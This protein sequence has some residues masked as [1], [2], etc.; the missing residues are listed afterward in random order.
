MASSPIQINDRPHSASS[1]SSRG[2]VKKLPPIHAQDDIDL[3]TD[4]RQTSEHLE[5]VSRTKKN[6]KFPDNEP[7]PSIGAGGDSLENDKEKEEDGSVS[8]KEQLQGRAD[9][10]NEDDVDSQTEPDSSPELVEEDSDDESSDSEGSSSVLD[11]PGEG[12]THPRVARGYRSEMSSTDFPPEGK[13]DHAVAFS[14]GSDGRGSVSPG[15]KNLTRRRTYD[16]REVVFATIDTQTD[17]NWMSSV[18]DSRRVKHIIPRGKADL[19]DGRTDRSMDTP[20]DDKTTDSTPFPGQYSDE[21]GIPILE[22]SSDTDESSDEGSS[23]K[24]ERNLMPNVGPPQ[25]LQ[26]IR[27]SEREETFVK[28][29]D[30]DE[31]DLDLRGDSGS[32]KLI[33][34]F[35]GT[36]EF[37]G[38]AVKPMPSLEQQAKESP[39]KLY[40]C[41]GYAEFVEFS[42]TA[43]HMIEEEVKRK[44]K[45]I[46]VKVHAH[47]GSK[48][49]RRAAKERA[50]QRIREREMQRKQQ[51]VQGLQQANF[52]ALARQMKTINYSLSS[53]RCL[54]EGWT[55][56]PPSPLQEEEIQD[57]F[58]AEPVLM[59]TTLQNKGLPC[60]ERF[61]DDGT[62]FL[63]IFADGTGNVFY[64]SGNV[65]IMITA[66]E[67]PNQFIYLICEDKPEERVMAVFEP[68]GT[69]CC[70]H[71]NGVIRVFIDKLGGIEL[72]A[73]G[74]KKRR[75]KWIDMEN[76]V[77]APPLQ[78]I[79][80]TLTKY[81]GIRIMNQDNIAVTFSCKKSSCRFNVGVKLKLVSLENLENL[82]QELDDDQ[83][84]LEEQRNNVQAVLDKI[85]NLLKFPKSPKIDKILPPI[86][87][88]SKIH[89]TEKLKK[90]RAKQIAARAAESPKSKKCLP[91]ITVN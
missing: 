32:E 50:V 51:D 42:I 59:M 91:V 22:L 2:S 4:K 7:L 86:H 72:E 90:T 68:N 11:R 15:F 5:E 70:Y 27:E 28:S 21:Y 14:P 87:L 85:S 53:N 34:M 35:C 39:E 6:V 63:T 8:A 61:Y 66:A 13:T 46:D 81:I 67:K 80:F 40:C 89:K 65:A 3:Q 48:Q 69:G 26:Y 64:P 76:H 19:Q 17:W 52:Y 29:P 47:H 9:N 74:A 45:L 58:E 82:Q 16:G 49:A 71:S 83:I 41:N 10:K 12:R 31:E 79:C 38:N 78:P 55:I 30:G 43:S 62:K 54:D 1:V 36:C 57:V 44:E 25:I 73:S 18:A 20:F 88:T 84:Y 75:W 56:R 77:H 60:I 23:R 37:C 33:M 24:D